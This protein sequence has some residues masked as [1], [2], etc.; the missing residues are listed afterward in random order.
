MHSCSSP[1]WVASSQ[2]KPPRHTAGPEQRRLAT[3]PGSSFPQPRRHW[4]TVRCSVGG[5]NAQQPQQQQRQPPSWTEAM[6]QPPAELLGPQPEA[7]ER[8]VQPRLRP[9]G[10]EE[11]EDREEK[12]KQKGGL[13]AGLRRQDGEG[14]VRKPVSGGRR[15]TWKQGG[16]GT[17]G[18]QV[19]GV[20]KGK[21][22]LR[23]RAAPRQR[24]NSAGT[25]RSP[26]DSPSASLALTVD[27]GKRGQRGAKASQGAK[28]ALSRCYQVAHAIA[29]LPEE[30]TVGK[31]LE[32]EQLS[33]KEMSRVLSHLDKLGVTERAAQVV[34][35]MEVRQ[36]SGSDAPD[37]FL[38]S[39]LVSLLARR[40]DTAQQAL[41]IFSSLKDEQRDVWC[42][43]A[44]ISAAAKLNNLKLAM[45]L[46]QTMD[47]QQV[48]GDVV[49]YTS[50]L[51]AC[52]TC[53]S[54]EQATAI[55][56]LMA[57]RGV[58]PNVK[59]Y[60]TAISAFT[61]AGDW[62]RAMELFDD[63]EEA[64]VEADIHAYNSLLSA[65]AAAGSWH[66]ARDVFNAI[67]RRGVQ[68]DV[69]S[70]NA[71]MSALE[72][73]EQPDRGL[74]LL[75]RMESSEG[76]KSGD[77][78]EP[79]PDI[80]PN[81]VTYNTLLSCLGKAK[82]LEDARRVLRQMKAAGL[83]P[84]A[85][86]C[87]A[88]MVACDR[89]QQWEAAAQLFEE[90]RAAGVELNTTNYNSLLS[91]FRNAKEV[92]R[93]LQLFES[94]KEPGSHVEVDIVT[95]STLISCLERSGEWKAALERFDQMLA[96]GLEPNS[97][98][99]Q[100]VLS[101]CEKGQEWKKAVEVCDIMA[102][103][104][105][106]PPALDA[107]MS[108]LMLTLGMLAPMAQAAVNSGKAARRWIETKKPHTA[109]SVPITIAAAAARAK[110]ADTIGPSGPSQSSR[111]GPLP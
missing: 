43:N 35:W 90:F 65:C 21:G 8:L 16:L 69:R 67:R 96:A 17:S 48:E 32:S 2:W 83:Q 12:G 52:Q 36:G 57:E 44:A 50:L 40:R 91:V 61:R 94:M 20:L 77:G 31:V 39:K 26:K 41:E 49:T 76:R 27:S 79:M 66:K 19:D 109:V 105:M 42:F 80:T 63:M 23:E 53:A 93:A 75:S 59:T 29:S 97:Y 62:E 86:T 25:P 103:S 6:A 30:Q 107:L 15:P 38:Y 111:K 84:D 33:L 14:E 51:K 34:R 101:A 5:F 37:A 92:D 95:Y 71:F 81:L 102:S 1:G 56:Q 78:Q 24:G 89:T 46:L 68:P 10:R 11:V 99:F 110:P 73:C 55:L 7:A 47:E 74:Q 106:P 85:V 70:Y 13:L 64:G 45:S 22:S 18:N 4:S 104:G 100:A 28:K 9:K 82:R 54:A 98:I 58:D 87:T 60:T 88:M 72:R 3:D 108:R